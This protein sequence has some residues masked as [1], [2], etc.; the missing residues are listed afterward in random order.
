L[1][2]SKTSS[3]R[4]T[5]QGTLDVE[6]EGRAIPGSWREDQTEMSSFLPL[7]RIA[8]KPSMEAKTIRDKF[9]E[10]FNTSGKIEWQDKYC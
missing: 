3:T 6:I 9:A 1:R 8:R 2:R 7:T 5:P 10:Y 4:Y